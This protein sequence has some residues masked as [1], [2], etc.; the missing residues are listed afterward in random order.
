VQPTLFDTDDAP[1]GA[2]GQPVEPAPARGWATAAEDKRLS[3][4]CQAILD[5]L[6]QGEATNTE[7]AAIALKYTSRLSDL[8][9]A[10]IDVRVINRDHA[11]GRVTYAI[12]S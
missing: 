1:T 5:R 9:A 11:T 2:Y 12:A 3:A 4:Q 10:G 7:L 8:R 6:K